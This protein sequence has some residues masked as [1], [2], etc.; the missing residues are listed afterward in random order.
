[1][2]WDGRMTIM[3]PTLLDLTNKKGVAMMKANDRVRLMSEG[4]E[5]KA[6]WK[7]QTALTYL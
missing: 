7:N 3:I 5:S 6:V 2:H 1:L 4:N